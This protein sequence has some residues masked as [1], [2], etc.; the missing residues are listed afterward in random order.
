MPECG[1]NPCTNPSLPIFGYHAYAICKV[2]LHG[3]CGVFS[4]RY[5]IKYQCI[6]HACKKNIQCT[7][8]Q[9]AT[10]ITSTIS[11]SDTSL[12]PIQ[13]F[14]ESYLKDPSLVVIG[15]P[16]KLIPNNLKKMKSKP[17]ISRM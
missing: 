1:A 16:S 9:S 5:S 11:T 6:C 4:F 10:S 2:E 12:V 7:F 13:L 17:L 14:K 3:P 8:N 15:L